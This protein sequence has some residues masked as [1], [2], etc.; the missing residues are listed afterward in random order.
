MDKTIS[1]GELSHGIL[2]GLLRDIYV[3]RLTGTLRFARGRER[4]NVRFE[5]G[6]IA[7]AESSL[8]AGRLGETMVAEGLITRAEL[9]R[10]VTQAEKTSR[11]FGE[12][13]RE[14]GLV[15]CGGVERALAA[16]VRAAL[17]TVFSWG[18]GLVEFEAEPPR[19]RGEATLPLST[20]E[21]V[22]EAVR[23]VKDP[24]AVRLGLGDLARLLAP[25][26]DPLLRFQRVSLTPVEGFLLS[27]VDGR[28]SAREVLQLVTGPALEAERALL[29]LL[30]VGLVD[31]LS[32]VREATPDAQAL[33]RE[34]TEFVRYMG[35]RS[36]FDVLGVSPEDPPE[37][38]EAAFFRLARRYHPD[39]HHDPALR[40][41]RDRL[42]GAFVRVCEAWETLRQP[43]KA[44]AYAAAL[45]RAPRGRGEPG[46]EPAVSEEDRRQQEAVLQQAE[47]RLRE[48]RQWEAVGLLQA[49]IPLSRG[50]IRSRAR[51]RLAQAQLRKADTVREAE[52]ELRALV[53]EE[54][55]N[56]DAR[57]ALAEFCLEHG[58]KRRARHLLEEV[59]TIRPGHRQ[60]AAQLQA[61]G[62]EEQDKEKEKLD[63]GKLLRKPLF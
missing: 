18:E 29:G 48:G 5:K 14:M 50:R 4:L 61:A 46:P 33:R 42:H 43:D 27:R 57:M 59:L 62:G 53:Q 63:L 21:I 25:S 35:S 20:G 51:L 22:L 44:G 40:D 1:G 58:H 16:Q 38:V 12:V 56:V 23:R 19:A 24:A 26:T 36:H 28:T 13:V 15:D 8:H 55:E 11:R 2:P 6:H 32:D 47:E 9:R 60:A 45:A 37:R 3:R 30:S 10:A 31:F 17:L 41:L 54:A 7:R 34:V 49:L 52:K 39:S